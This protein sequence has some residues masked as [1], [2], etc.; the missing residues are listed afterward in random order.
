ML[1]IGHLHAEQRRM[2]RRDDPVQDQVEQCPSDDDG[3]EHAH[4]HTDA[5]GQGKPLDDAGAKGATEPEK[6]AAR[7]Q[8]RKVGV[9]NRRPGAL[10][11]QVGGLAQAAPAQLVPLE[12]QHVGVDGPY[13]RR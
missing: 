9:S 13:R 4:D 2:L 7:D 11:T 1:I 8:G 12:Y 5:Q 10:E 6:D 3:G